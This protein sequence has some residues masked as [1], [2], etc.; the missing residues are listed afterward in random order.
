MNKINK[1]LLRGDSPERPQSEQDTSSSAW[2]VFLLASWSPRQNLRLWLSGQNGGDG[3]IS[4]SFS[5]SPSS[6]ARSKGSRVPPLPGASKRSRVRELSVKRKTGG[7]GGGVRMLFFFSSRL[8]P[9]RRASR[10]V[11][12]PGGTSRLGASSASEG[13]GDRKRPFRYQIS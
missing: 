9:L 12:S 4:V 8:S 2:P 10:A 5:S 6:S 7:G 1:E 11:A 3:A 13:R